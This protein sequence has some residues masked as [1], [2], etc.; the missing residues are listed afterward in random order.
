MCVRQRCWLD[1]QAGEKTVYLG[2]Y[3][4]DAPDISVEIARRMLKAWACYRKYTCNLLNRS[5]SDLKLQVRMLKAEVVEALLLYGCKLSTPLKDH[6]MEVHQ[7]HH[8][9]LPR[10]IGWRKQNLADHVHISFRENFSRTGRDGSSMQVLSP[11]WRRDGCR[12]TL[13]LVRYK[14][15]DVSTDNIAGKNNTFQIKRDG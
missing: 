11:T 7:T 9:L 6:Y 8:T 13:C 15:Y 14:I 1:I 10:W 3:I 2:G 12:N 4:S 5:S